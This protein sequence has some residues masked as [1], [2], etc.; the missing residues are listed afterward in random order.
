MLTPFL[1]IDEDNRATI[2][3]R[4][5]IDPRARP[6]GKIQVIGIESLQR[7]D[8]VRPSC[9]EKTLSIL[10]CDLALRA[11][12]RMKEH[13]LRHLYEPNLELR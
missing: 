4:P 6:Y 8:S 9:I 13:T 7:G 3:M 11:Q 12:I 2:T 1:I 10:P 5:Y